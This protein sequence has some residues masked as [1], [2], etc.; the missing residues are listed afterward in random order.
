MADWLLGSRIVYNHDC[1]P[2]HR[3]P[4]EARPDAKPEARPEVRT[5]GKHSGA[6]SGLVQAESLMQIALVLPCAMLIGWGAGWWVDDHFHSQWATLAGLV[7]GLV[8]GMVS[9]VR[10][11]LSAGSVRGRNDDGR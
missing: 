5:R 8:A 7:L 4:P 6:L 3:S 2:F 10:M 1:M 9:V 11:A